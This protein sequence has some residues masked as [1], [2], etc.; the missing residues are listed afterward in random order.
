MT[1]YF[2]LLAVCFFTACANLPEPQHSP[3]ERERNGL[4]ARTLSPGECGLFVWTGDASRRFILFSQSDIKKAAWYGPKG[5]AE[6]SV[7]EYSGEISNRQHPVQT[8]QLMSGDELTV[9]LNMSG[10]EVVEGGT[11]YKRGS[12]TVMQS[13]AWDKVMPVIG[14]STCQG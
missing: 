6:L 3:T 8:L 4:T 1:R 7:T 14:L 2:T 10:R 12:L 13:E 11:R 5:E 9:R